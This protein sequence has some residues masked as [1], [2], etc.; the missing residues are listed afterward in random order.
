[1]RILIDLNGDYSNLQLA[2]AVV[3]RRGEHQILILLNSADRSLVTTVRND[4]HDLLPRNAIRY[5]I[6]PE[7]IVGAVNPED[8]VKMVMEIFEVMIASLEVDVMLTTRIWEKSSKTA[9][10]PLCIQL[11]SFENLDRTDLGLTADKILVDCI[12]N[13]DAFSEK[14]LQKP[15]ER[16]L[17]AFVSPLPPLKSGIAEYSA[18]LLQPLLKYY[19]IILITDQ[20]EV[21]DSRLTDDFPIREPGWLLANHDLFERIIYHFGNSP[22]HRYMYDLLAFVPGIVV[23]HDFFLLDGQ[24]GWLSEAE[25]RE[26]IMRDHG[27][28]ALMD[29]PKL[30]CR[31]PGVQHFPGNLEVLQSAT[32]IIIHGEES[33]RLA[34]KWYGPESAKTWHHIPHLRHAAEVSHESRRDARSKLGFAKDDIVICSFG[35]IGETKLN[36]ETL[37]ALTRSQLASDSR[38]RLIFVGEAQEKYKAMLL[39][40]ASQLPAAQFHITGWVNTTSYEDHLQA[41]DIAVQLRS[42]SRG[43]T[44]GSVLDCMNY[45]LP[46]IVNAHGSMRD[47]DVDAVFTIDDPVD[48]RV[49]ASALEQLVVDTNLRSRIS[50]RS[51]QIIAER[52]APEACANSYRMVIEHSVGAWR[53]QLSRLPIK[54]KRLTS[55]KNNLLEIA[56]SLAFNFPPAPRQPVLFIDVSAVAAQDIHTGIQRV[57]RSVLNSLFKRRDLAHQIV[58]VRLAASG[59]FTK[60]LRLAEKVA[61]LS[62]GTTPEEPI[63]VFRGDVFIGV[64]LDFS[65]NDVRRRNFDRFREAGAEI[66][67]VV[68]DLLPIEL[69]Q[70]FPEPDSALFADWLEM[71]CSYDGVVCDS[72]ATADSLRRWFSERSPLGTPV[73]RIGWFHLGADL[74]NSVPTSGLPQDAPQLISKLAKRPTFVMVGTVEP[75]KGHAQTLR[76]F[77]KLWSQ[78]VEAN[79]LI[80]GKEGWKI[81]RLAARLR[82]HAEKDERLFWLDGISDEYL[83][84]VYQ[85]CDCLIAASEG[86]GFGLPLIEAA[87]HQLPI[88][89]RDIPVFREVAGEHAA[90]FEGLEAETLA[91]AVENWL[92]G[93]AVGRIIRSDRMPWLTWDQS[94]SMLIK[95]IGISCKMT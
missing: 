42:K 23:L 95:E 6:A 11:D 36:L 54:L 39:K 87:Q 57:V 17:L 34:E 61:G 56:K 51:K 66:W 14:K 79:L 53:H 91:R 40:V 74:K 70:F 92:S 59:E 45:G 90:Y 7:K 43:E 65:R 58:P 68:Y 18:Q 3:R 50:I 13:F 22:I 38:I 35:H 84:R 49:L 41:A 86:E 28:S 78:G 48:E 46:T 5:W 30:E 15:F 32:D 37:R 94:A 88:L 44:S 71:V 10:L 27:M 85:S 52:H 55:E 89:A 64:D 67:H 62:V 82:H 25:R 12:K 29:A 20:I 63:D 80:V 31:S 33:C 19:R 69:P 21:L 1:M 75:R 2:K 16:P 93:H 8:N 83:E 73:P 4:F 81:E 26:I 72:A 76:A 77:E 24:G 47:L 60:A 9:D